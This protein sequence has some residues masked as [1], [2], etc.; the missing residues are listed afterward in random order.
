MT[1]HTPAETVSLVADIGGTNAR[2]ALWSSGELSHIQVLPC[3][4]YPGAAAAMKHYLSGVEGRRPTQACIAV[5]T[6]ANQDQIE[7]TNNH[8]SFSVDALREDMGF[9]RLLVIN[10][11]TSLALS[12]PHLPDD[13][14][15]K[16]GGA[17]AKADAPIA[18]IGPGTGLGVSGLIPVG[19]DQWM[20]IQGEGGHVTATALND[21]QHQVIQRLMQRYPHVSAERIISGQG[22][23]N[24][25]TSIVELEGVEPLPLESRHITQLAMEQSNAHCQEALDIFCRQLGSVAA[26]VALTLGALG[27]VYV[28]GGIVPKL[29]DY[30]AQSGF[31]EA[32][33][34]K[35]RFRDYL[36]PIPVYAIHSPYPALVG[37]AQAL[38][39]EIGPLG[40]SSCV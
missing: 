31:R 4:D 13:E 34:A 1:S 28:G 18:L 36:T 3:A 8:W 38:S 25:Y 32:F 12:L 9:E 30:F 37:S 33:E 26:D 40:V 17:S 27:G 7:F 20:P 23:V 29:G 2:F 15:H 22:L 6:S 16:L 10:D 5:A 14:L 39:Y 11:F 21:R 35:G 24:L 19:I